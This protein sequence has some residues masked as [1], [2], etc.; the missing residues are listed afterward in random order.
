MDL[1]SDRAESATS[2]TERPTRGAA[3][4]GDAGAE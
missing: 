3:Y 4:I 2:S 1:D